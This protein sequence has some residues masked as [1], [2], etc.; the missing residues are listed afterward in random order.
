MAIKI[1]NSSLQP[2][3]VL[4][5][6][7]SPLVSE[8]INR[9]LTASFQTVI[10]G[11]KSVY[12]TY[13]NIAEIEGNYFNIAYT[14]DAH[15]A[16][17]TLTIDVECEHVSYDLIG[18]ENDPADPMIHEYYTDVGTPTDLLTALLAGT[19]FTVGTV[20]FTALTTIAINERVSKRGILLT[21]AEQLGGELKFDKYEISLLTRRG[22]DNG[23]GFRYRR[24]LVSMSR[25]TDNR[26]K[27]D[28]LPTVTYDTEVVELE[29]AQGHGL[30]DHYE[31]GDTVYLF[32]DQ[33]GISNLPVRIIQE[34]HDPLQRMQGTVTISNLAGAFIKDIN[35]TVTN[36][37]QNTVVKDALYFGAKIGPEY[38]FE[39]ILSDNTARAFFNAIAFKMQKGD[40]TGNNWTD[41]LYFDPVEGEYTLDGRLIVKAASVL[42]AEIFKD[43]N[44]GVIKLYDSTGKLNVKLGVE[45][46]TGSNTGG[47]LILYKDF[48]S[49]DPDDYKRVESGVSTAD[50]FGLTN[51]RDTNTKVRVSIQGD[52][53]ANGPFIGIRNSSEAL[54]SY[55]AELVGY[56]N[57]EQIAVQ[58]WVTTQIA[59]A[60]AAHILAYH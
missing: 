35:D 4:L 51:Y 52:S 39:S 20:D 28:G 43:T 38:G 26:N 58:P 3:A 29:F 54:K 6:V 34:S 49:G 2:L 42:L 50:D 23:L 53:A 13:Q 44:G 18:D 19:N 8:E 47:T 31:L 32:D 15:N 21:L 36:L 59:D 48:A 7:V 11:D 25:I 9:E 10:D 27:V 30:D 57:L 45:S 12:V 46:G 1:L 40:G 60:I 24:N 22:A 16:D 5:N 56:I 17:D 37:Q 33:L 14:R 55:L 41:K